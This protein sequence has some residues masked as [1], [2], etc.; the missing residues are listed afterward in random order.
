MKIETVKKNMCVNRL[1][2]QTTERFIL[3]EDVIIPDIKPDI[4]KP[5]SSNGNIC[6]YKQEVLE[7]KIKLEGNVNIYIVYLADSERDN[8]RGINTNLDFKET[9]ECKLAM[10]GMRVASQVTI[11]SI[12]CKVLNGRKINIK[13]E[14]EAEMRLYSNEELN[15]VSDIKNIED[16]QEIRKDRVLSSI[17]GS[18]STK[19]YA[20]ETIKFDSGDNLAEILRVDLNIV[21]K[22]V[23]ISYNK[24]LAKADTNVKIV[25]LTEDNRIRCVEEKI[26]VMGFIEMID[27]AEDDNCDVTY[28][29]KNMIIKPNS[30]EEHSIYVE[31]EYELICNAFREERVEVIEDLYSPSKNLQFNSRDIVTIADT[32]KRSNKC[33]IKERISI[34]ELAGEKINDIKIT[35]NINNTIISNGKLTYEG[36]VRVDF[37]I[38]S[39]NQT[40]IE[41]I[42][43]IVPFVH[44][45]EQ[46]DI[47]ENTK[48][49]TNIEIIMQDFVINDSEVSLNICLNFEVNQYNQL[50][51]RI[52]EEVEENE[53]RENVNPYSMTIYFVKEGDTLW[54]IAKKYK[55]TVDDIVKLNEIENPDKISEGMQLFIPKYVCERCN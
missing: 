32:R 40:T 39:N 44:T 2:T 3:E 19:T 18:N 12:E 4:L 53:D 48:I 6:I 27:I 30:E 33:D 22:D 34:Q 7:E 38:T 45:I 47:T 1:V 15:I 14:I 31:I 28:I 5:I 42:V 55:S 8:I 36:E 24:I 52:I 35:P 21:N 11:K 29:I 43:K 10:N 51:I 9:I 13:V 26:P 17:V 25:Y 46:E 50:N 16:I 20:K 49:D 41:S 37:M 23:K 54:K